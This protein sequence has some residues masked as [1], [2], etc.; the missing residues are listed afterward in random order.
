MATV[1]V[2]ISDNDGTVLQRYTVTE[3]SIGDEQALADEL[4]EDDA[5]MFDEVADA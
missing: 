4:R 3:E 5:N 1:T 2:T